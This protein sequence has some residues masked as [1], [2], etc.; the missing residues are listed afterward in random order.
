M[1]NGSSDNESGDNALHKSIKYFMG[2]IDLA[3]ARH[4]NT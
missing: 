3:D 2:T 1:E 4:N